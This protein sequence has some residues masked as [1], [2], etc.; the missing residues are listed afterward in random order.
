MG[1]VQIFWGQTHIQRVMVFLVLD[2]F[3]FLIEEFNKI[4]ITD[5]IKVTQVIIIITA[6]IK[7]IFLVGGQMYYYTID[8]L[9]TSSVNSYE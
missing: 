8:V 4:K 3:F 1:A 2:Y 6:I 5:R 7:L 9:A